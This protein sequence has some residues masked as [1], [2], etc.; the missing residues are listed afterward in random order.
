MLKEICVNCN[1][2][3]KVHK[4]GVPAIEYQ[5]ALYIIPYK[6]WRCDTVQCPECK[7]VAAT[8]FADKPTEKHDKDFK[9]EVQWADDSPDVVRFH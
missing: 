9:K 1:R 6:V 2:R 5:D 7:T 4:I 8:R 3:M